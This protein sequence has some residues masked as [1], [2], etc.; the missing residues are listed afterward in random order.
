MTDKELLYKLQA[1]VLEIKIQLAEMNKLCDNLKEEIAKSTDNG[2]G[3][4]I[5]LDGV[6]EVYKDELIKELSSMKR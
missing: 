4:G 2:S 5:F 1:E 3:T 6:P